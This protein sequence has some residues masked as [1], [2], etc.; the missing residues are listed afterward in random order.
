VHCGHCGTENRDTAK[1][2]GACGDRLEHSCSSCGAPLA[3][4]L[5]FCDQCGTPT[6][7]VAETPAPAAPDAARKLV[8]VAFVDLG[9]ST[10]FGEIVDA[11]T[12]RSV[13]GRYHSLVTEAVETHGGTVAKYIG[14]GVMVFFGVPEVGEDDA[15]RAVAFGADV[16]ERFAPFAERVLDR[17]GATVTLRV[18]IN[19]GE[20]VIG[21]DD[22]DLYGDA[23]NVAARL[24]KACPH[25]GVLVGEETWRLARGTF[26]FEGQGEV[27]VHGRVGGVRPYLL[28]HDTVVEERNTPF[29][30]RAD[31]LDRLGRLFT[32]TVDTRR[33]GLASVIGPP[34]IGKTRLSRELQTLVEKADAVVYTTAC[35]R[36]GDA[37]LGPIADLLRPDDV[38]DADT[39]RANLTGLLAGEDDADRVVEGLVAILG[40]ATKKVSVEETFWALRR[41][42]ERLGRA[43]PIVVIVDDIQWASDQLLDLFEHLATYVVDTPLLLVTLARP[44]IRDLRPAFAEA[45]RPVD[46]VVLLTGLDAEST[47]ALAVRL[48]GG[49]ELPRGLAER[50][51]SSTDGNPLFVREVVRMLL[52]EE[53]VRRNGDR[54]VLTVEPDAIDVPSTV[55][56][57]LAA[58]V[59][60]LP[61]D[62]RVVLERAAVI[63][64]DFTRAG[65]EHLC[66]ETERSG[67]PQVLR[68]LTRKELIEAT[69]SYWGDDPVHRFHHVLIRDAVYRRLLKETRAGLHERIGEWVERASE[70]VLGEHDAAIGHHFE[71]AFHYRT[72]LGDDDDAVVALGARAADRLADAARVALR[73]DDT[74]A[75]GALAR[76]ALA[77]LAHDTPARPQ[78]LT[79][80]CE[81]LLDVG[82]ATTARPFIDELLALAEFEPAVAGPRRTTR[83]PSPSPSPTVS[84]TPRSSPP[85]RSTP[86]RW[87]TIRPA[88]PRPGWFERRSS[89]DAA[90]SANAKPNWM[91]H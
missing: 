51:P 85:G 79:L 73:S 91:Q 56:S 43:S 15:V 22:V 53:I 5:K 21:K 33:P 17:H 67:L 50:L 86:S 9:G 59:E 44:E 19:T 49:D 37:T 34:G 63:G 40:L 30:G 57:L 87:G 68:S 41:L 52:D 65:L 13:M 75:A 58:R 16:Q 20:I 55:Q 54:W 76:R 72:D 14:D 90:A 88:R 71:Q 2:C 3:G 38:V 77:C 74:M 35:D 84:P 78:T 36:D 12:A 42:V 69:G 32:D 89:P 46:E 70:D 82:D 66:T 39:V 7:D 1:F 60:R 64:P 6:A 29:V 47:A 27:E 81:A 18:G 8:T 62:E 23:L 28:T 48:L 80:A 45:G 24:E 26:A 31:E 61:A 11:E 25:G 10:A 83:R 4:G